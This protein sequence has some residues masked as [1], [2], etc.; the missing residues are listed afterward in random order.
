MRDGLFIYSMWGGYRN[1]EYQRKFENCLLD[2]GFSIKTI[3][4]S[5]HASVSDIQRLIC[6]LNPLRIVPIHT[7]EPQAFMGFSE[8][9]KMQVDGE[10]FEV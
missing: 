9:V 10:E 7:M 8:K 2:A 1:T 4:T 5:G 6:E 3:H